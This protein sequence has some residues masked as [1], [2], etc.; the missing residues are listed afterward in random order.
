MPDER[1]RGQVEPNVETDL[2]GL[3]FRDLHVEHE[4]AVWRLDHV[5]TFTRF[6]MYAG[7]L[8]SALA[9]FAV[10]VGALSEKRTVGLVLIA[11]VVVIHLV[12]AWLTTQDALLWLMLPFAAIDNFFG[13]VLA[14]AMTMQLDNFAITAGCITMAA[15]FGLSMFRMRPAMAAVAVT[16]YIAI[17]EALAVAKFNR[18]EMTEAELIIGIFIPVTALI[19]GLV[20]CIGTERA[21]RRTYSDQ[22]IIESQRS[23]LAFEHSN[24]LRFMSPEVAEA[25]RQQGVDTALA[26]EMLPL[27]VICTDLR[28]FTPFT[29]HYGAEGMATV[30][31]E[32]YEAVI[33]TTRVFGGM[34]KDFAGDGALVLM[35]APLPRADH[36]RTGM[37][38]ARGLVAAVRR[39]TEE[40][41]T[42]ETPLGVG[43]GIASGECA[44][45]AIGSHSRLEYT[46]VGTAVNLAARL[47]SVAE[48]GQIVIAPST[49][50]LVDRLPSWR[51]SL[52]S[53]KGFDEPLEVDVEQTIV[54]AVHASEVPLPGD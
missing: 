15:Y 14:I 49:A 46:A 53:V 36:A 5:R 54:A 6:A 23:L 2:W 48:D 42:E 29:Q 52:V 21:T 17:A 10:L 28:G 25:V 38:L 43:V 31:R 44:V 51:P 4:Y 20:L 24:L 13:G 7:G 11:F 50:R 26:P 40:F 27:T 45:G 34:V 16:S 22:R 9:W 35:G 12:G 1:S 3:R 30:L 8:A 47:C 32:Y 41:G 33:E 18:G 37:E 19:T 39:I